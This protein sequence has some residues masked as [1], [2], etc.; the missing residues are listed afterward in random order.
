MTT[1]SDR[2]AACQ[3]GAD[4]GFVF[5]MAFQ[6]IVD[7]SD[8]SVYA[9]EALARGPSGEPSG[10]VFERVDRDQPYAFDQ[11]SRVR[12]IELASTLGLG[13][14]LSINFLPNAVYEPER[15]IQTTLAAARRTGFPIDD[16]VFEVTEVEKVADSDHLRTI[17]ESYKRQGFTTAIDDFGAGYAGLS[18][19]ADFQ[20]DLVKLDM[21]LVRDIDTDPT[22]RAIVGG[23]LGTCKA[24]GI[25]VIAEGVETRDEAR[26]L[27]EMGVHLFQGYYFARPGF[28][29]LPQ[30]PAEILADLA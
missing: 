25:D 28:E 18:L 3:D 24:L 11:T 10:W 12:A 2:C 5:S 6:P 16:I 30:V 29:T 21:H 20:P 23:L 15:C 9:Y 14:R 22:K 26:A 13:N 1:D 27:R 4:L 7:I 19:L 8:R 17:I